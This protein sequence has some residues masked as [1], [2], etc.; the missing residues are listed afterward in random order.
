MNMSNQYWRVIGDHLRKNVGSRKNKSLFY[1]ISHQSVKVSFV[2]SLQLSKTCEQ[3]SQQWR[4]R[5]E[6]SAVLP[7][8]D[9][10]IAKWVPLRYEVKSTWYVNVGNTGIRILWD[11]LIGN[12][13]AKHFWQMTQIDS[14]RLDLPLLLKQIYSKVKNLWSIWDTK[15][16]QIE[17]LQKSKDFEYILKSLL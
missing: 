15:S 5:I 12:S 4:R 6:L 8:L 3:H 16:F 13:C 7:T 2:R 14:S 1:N 9:L 11:D 10:P 17:K